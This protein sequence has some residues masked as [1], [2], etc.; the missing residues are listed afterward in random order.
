[1]SM[2]GLFPSKSIG[3]QSLGYLLIYG[4]AGF[5]SLPSNSLEK[6]ILQFF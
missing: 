2:Q 5:S 1:M 6:I 4:F 3:L